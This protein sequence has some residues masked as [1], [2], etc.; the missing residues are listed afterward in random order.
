MTCM[1]TGFVCVAKRISSFLCQMTQQHFTLEGMPLIIPAVP[2][3]DITS[4]WLA[5]FGYPKVYLLWWLKCE[6]SG[7]DHSLRQNTIASTHTLSCHITTTNGLRQT[8]WMVCC[9]LSISYLSLIFYTHHHAVYCMAQ[10][11]G[12]INSWQ[13]IHYYKVLVRK[14]WV[15]LQ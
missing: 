3:L 7:R 9:S 14:A 6:T 13:I 10:H 11:S 8:S 12:G 1:A 5:G 15:N 2:L 4:R